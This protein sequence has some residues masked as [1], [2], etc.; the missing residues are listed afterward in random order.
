MNIG[1]AGIMPDKPDRVLAAK[2]A[3][4]DFAESYLSGLVTFDAAQIKEF[5]GFL[6]ESNLPCISHNGMFP[7]DIKLIGAEADRQRIAE[8]TESAL[9]LVAPLG[10]KLC[11]LGSGGS[12]RTP[13]GYDIDRAYDEFSALCSEIIAPIC[14][15]YGKILV[16][17][18]LNRDECNIVNTVADAARVVKAINK[19][20]VKA[21]ADY[22]HVLKNGED[23]SEISQ[24]GDILV[25]AHI[26]S[27]ERKIPMP[28]DGTDYKPFFDVLRKMGY[29]AENIS[30]EALFPDD[31]DELVRMTKESYS[32]LKNL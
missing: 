10:A 23:V 28:C 5:A 15:K 3:G 7:S 6:S 11:V 26:S 22:F 18:P 21:L 1:I 24:Y 29:S 31:G 4:L 9:S 19:P 13:K 17:E 2:K 30:I 14:E 27:I 12:R 32:F 16:I 8:Y 20:S 25:H